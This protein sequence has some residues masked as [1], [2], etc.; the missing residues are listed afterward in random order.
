MKNLLLILVIVSALY[1]A[2]CADNPTGADKIPPVVRLYTPVAND[3]LIV[4]SHEI[5]FEASD[6]QGIKMAE[7]Y[8]DGAIKA[9]VT[10]PASGVRPGLIWKVAIGDTAGKHSYYIKVYDLSNNA[11]QTEPRGGITVLYTKNP[12]STPYNVRIR[13]ITDYIINI[14]WQDTSSYVTGYELW[15][16]DGLNG[17]YV[18]IKSLPPDAF[19]TNDAGLDPKVRYFYKLRGFNPFGSSEYSN[20]VASTLS[21]GSPDI[22]YPTNLV[23]KILAK[24]KIQLS[25]TDNSSNENFFQVERKTGSTGTFFPIGK[26]LP[27]NTTTF[28]DSAYGLQPGN[29]YEYRVKAYSD[30]DSSWSNSLAVRTPDYNLTKPSNLAAARFNTNTIRIIWTDNS[31]YETSTIIE[32]KS[33]SNTAYTQIGTV[34]TDITRFDDTSFNVGESYTYRVRGTDG[35]VYSEYSNEASITIP[36]I[37]R[38]T[39]LSAVKTGPTSVRLTWTDNSTNE[40]AFLIERRSFTNTTYQLIGVITA[41]STQYDDTNALPGETYFYRVRATD[42]YHYSDYSNEFSI[43]MTLKNTT[44]PKQSVK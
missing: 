18:K 20:E 37:N 13:N 22:P 2:G 11:T 16:K 33:T 4:G 39:N 28:L 17:T 8:V 43:A 6:D 24:D 40:S 9:S 30:T 14:F 23:A 10:V 26:P 38:P 7:L 19:N 31:Q 36:P 35:L 44:A 21:N 5:I 27:P 32:R 41:N 1:L 12:P 34:G 15:R 42:D 25:W 3:T 29:D